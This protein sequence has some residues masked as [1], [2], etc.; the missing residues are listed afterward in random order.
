[1]V[2]Q[3]AVGMKLKIAPKGRDKMAY[4]S[5]EDRTEQTQADHELFLQAF[6][7]ELIQHLRLL[8]FKHTSPEPTQ[9]YRY[10]RTRNLISPIFLN[11]TL[12]FMKKRMSRTNEGRKA[13]K[14]GP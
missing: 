14:V 11:R 13:F 5:K 12:R 6:E 8:I 3:Q 2:V 9:I 10:L 1:L 4:K 7:S